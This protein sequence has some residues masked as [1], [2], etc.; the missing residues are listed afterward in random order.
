MRCEAQRVLVENSVAP[1]S[2]G[3][4]P[5]ADQMRNFGFLLF[6]F[7]AVLT[8]MDATTKGKSRRKEL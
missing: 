3:V 2:T 8:G 7:G 1:Q 5:V 6:V 4:K